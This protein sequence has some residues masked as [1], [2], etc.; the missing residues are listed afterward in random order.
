MTDTML[1]SLLFGCDSIEQQQYLLCINE[2][3]QLFSQLFIMLFLPKQCAF[4]IPKYLLYYFINFLQIPDIQNVQFVSPI[5]TVS[6]YDS[7][8][9]LYQ[10][11]KTYLKY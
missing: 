2:I 3:K 7:V 6:V 4:A 5:F 8:T 9:L 10:V 11:L 1:A